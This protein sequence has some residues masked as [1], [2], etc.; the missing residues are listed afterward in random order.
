MTI[1]HSLTHTKVTHSLRNAR[2]T[3]TI[4][5][6]D[7]NHL[8]RELTKTLLR[9]VG[10]AVAEASNG[11]SAIQ[12][13]QTRRY[14]MLITDLEMPEMDGFELARHL[15]KDRAALPVLVLSG[16]LPNVVP[17]QELQKRRWAFLPKPVDRKELIRT[18]D[19]NCLGWALHTQPGSSPQRSKLPIE[20][21]TTTV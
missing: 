1:P 11:Q 3:V 7:D 13:A 2:A 12:Q 20:T 10:Y 6:V 4:L 17:L 8:V 18:I 15:T 9:Q 21:M 16:A 19:N 5:L 14:D